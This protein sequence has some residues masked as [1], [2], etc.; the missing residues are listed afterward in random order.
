MF[1]GEHEVARPDIEAISTNDVATS[2]IAL[3]FMIILRWYINFQI[4]QSTI[5]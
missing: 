5:T 1:G 3:S 4:I 2:S